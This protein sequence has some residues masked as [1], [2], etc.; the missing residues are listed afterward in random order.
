MLVLCIWLSFGVTTVAADSAWD[1]DPGQDGFDL[2]GQ[3]HTPGGGAQPAPPHPEVGDA[4]IVPTVEEVDQW[5]GSIRQC[6]GDAQMAARGAGQAWDVAGARQ[7][8]EGTPTPADPAAPAPQVTAD[9]VYTEL[10]KVPLP[11]P[12]FVM[13][14]GD[15]GLVNLPQIFYSTTPPPQPIGLTLLGH[16]VTLTLTATYEWHVAP[17]TT[18]VT[19]HP[20]A[21]YPNQTITHTYTDTGTVEVSLTM[22]YGGTFTVDGGSPQ[23]ITGTVTMQS[24]P[25]SLQILSAQPELVEGP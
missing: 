25:I 6:M 24:A 4:A 10:Q 11:T 23:P 20:G 12:G 17:D 8:C 19:D 2:W 16:A 15:R 3:E 1:A 22:V 21:A 14:P 13:Q 5:L 7:T 9:L 18:L